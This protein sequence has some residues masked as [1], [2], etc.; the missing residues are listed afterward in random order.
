MEPPRVRLE[1]AGSRVLTRAVDSVAA[2]DALRFQYALGGAGW[3]APGP[4]RDFTLEEVEQAG[5][6]SVRVE[7]PAGWT[8]ESTFRVP[9]TEERAG[10]QAATT[11][12]AGC[13]AAPHRLF[14]PA[15]LLALFAL[16][17]RR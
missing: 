15:A 4:S 9:R 13:A 10:G 1:R 3:S 2:A 5:G 17:R 16:R 6:L 11:L 12:P 7:D 14:L 8:A